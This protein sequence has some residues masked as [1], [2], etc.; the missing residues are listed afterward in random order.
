MRKELEQF[1]KENR[2][3]CWESDYENGEY[4]LGENKVI[5]FVEVIQEQAKVKVN[6]AED[7]RVMKDAQLKSVE[8]V[9]KSTDDKIIKEVHQ[10]IKNIVSII[11]D[12]IIEYVSKISE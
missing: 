10:K 11:Y 12:E 8:E 7:I 1:I 5:A 9:I 2:K 4:C 6:F 3:T